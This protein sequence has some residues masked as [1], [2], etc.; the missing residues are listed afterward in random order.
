VHDDR[1]R[2]PIEAEEIDKT[3]LQK[4][5]EERQE[6]GEQDLK[7]IAVQR[8]LR[9]VG[10]VC[11]TSIT[12]PH[13]R[14]LFDA[15]SAT[16]DPDRQTLFVD[17]TRAKEPRALRRLLNGLKRQR[18]LSKNKHLL[19]VCL[20]LPNENETAN[21][22]PLLREAQAA[23]VEQLAQ[24]YQ[25]DI[26]LYGGASAVSYIPWSGGAPVRVPCNP[27]DV[28]F[29]AEDKSERLKSGILLAYSLAEA[30][31]R[32]KAY[33]DK[34]SNHHLIALCYKLLRSWPG[35]KW[36]SIL[37]Y[38]V[39]LASATPKRHSN[40]NLAALFDRQTTSDH[41]PSTLKMDIRN[42]FTKQNGD[43][44]WKEFNLADN[45]FCSLS[46]L[47]GFRRLSK[48]SCAKLTLC[49]ATRP[50]CQHCTAEEDANH[51]RPTAA[52]LLDLDSTLLNST[53]ERARALLPA[54]LK[55]PISTRKDQVQQPGAVRTTDRTHVPSTVSTTPELSPAQFFEKCV[56]TLHPLFKLMG[57]GD[58]RQVWNHV[59]WYATYMVFRLHPQIE[60]DVAAGWQGTP[61]DAR[62]REEIS[63]TPWWQEF[64]RRYEEVLRLHADSIRV[65]Q[66][67][68]AN[69]PLSPLKEA[70]DFLESLKQT[71]ACRLYVV[72]EGDP[73]TQWLK[74]QLTGLNT[75]FTRDELLTTGDAAQPIT[76]LN[77]LYQERTALEKE[78][79]DSE[80]LRLRYSQ[81]ARTLGGMQK[82]LAFRL[83]GANPSLT[84]TV[85]KFFEESLNA[86]PRN[87]FTQASK[88]ADRLRIQIKTTEFAEH[89]LKRVQ[90][91]RVVS[92]YAAVI[93]AILRN[94]DYPLEELRSFDRL[95]EK[96]PIR[97]KLK[98]VM[99]GDRQENDIRPPMELL[100][101]KG[102]LT[103]RLLCGDY[104][105]KE[106]PEEAEPPF[107]DYIAHT[108]AQVK[109]FLLSTNA[110]NSVKC[111]GD[112]KL[113]NWAIDET[114][115][116]DGMALAPPRVEK[117]GD[118]IA[119]IGLDYLLYG[120][121]YSEIESITRK[122]CAGVLAE[123]LLANE[124]ALDRILGRTSRLPKRRDWPDV[125]A[126]TRFIVVA[127]LIDAGLRSRAIRA[128]TTDKLRTE[129]QSANQVFTRW[130]T[131]QR[132]E[133]ADRLAALIAKLAKAQDL[134]GAS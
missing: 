68:F 90:E 93:R 78:L 107:P 15:I 8:V 77:A 96:E 70:R 88:L 14:P 81:E 132:V 72:S 61:H 79:T 119:S 23:S 98:F 126:V 112:P 24:R 97:S 36:T 17:T 111:V 76:E 13:F 103:I 6:L 95:L 65:A 29:A 58:F 55:L 44:R 11:I 5:D 74:L 131:N 37:T 125:K 16:L 35:D 10:T 33:G 89:V 20:F 116:K 56:Y 62:N 87:F 120:I 19:P 48:C 69:M 47:A 53:R 51:G 130:Q 80:S 110:W 113:F 94:P 43:G 39:A 101:P 21:T 28:D 102:I 34:K 85:D 59:G 84:Q 31:R 115:D 82:D 134:L 83:E 42:D 40:C 45:H 46:R 122:V 63:T 104:A 18:E 129:L 60:R 64:E 127:A 92:F 32:L 12:T 66:T 124:D 50:E 75:V 128:A 114:T 123:H 52:I 73:E 118:A 133:A 27:H 86:I 91:K 1:G 4:A 100:G 9:N 109:A 117:E 22:L 25:V 49:A 3:D 106:K 71:G 38:S 7:S 26:I 105:I 30:I 99:L 2:T 54:L 108:L 41:V 121:R 57:K 67:E